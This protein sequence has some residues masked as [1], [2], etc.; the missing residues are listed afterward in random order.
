MAIDMR[1]I[2]NPDLLIDATAP[3]K[4]KPRLS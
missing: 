1:R 3:L 4:S 2:L